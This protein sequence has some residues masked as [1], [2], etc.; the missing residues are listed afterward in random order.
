MPSKFTHK[1]IT[2]VPA[3]CPNT[4]TKS[5]LGDSQPGAYYVTIVAW[6]EDDENLMNSM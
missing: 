1:N 3:A 4:I 5:L 2:G 6:H